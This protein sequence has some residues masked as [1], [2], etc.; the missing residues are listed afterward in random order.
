VWL[1]VLPSWGFLHRRLVL[2]R[3]T[4]L[5]LD[6]LLIR[7]DL[8][9]GFGGEPGMRPDLRDQFAVPGGDPLLRALEERLGRRL[10]A[11]WSVLVHLLEQDRLHERVLRTYY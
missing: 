1:D 8:L 6:L 9:H 7:R 10:R 4:R 2:S 5:R 3:S 11:E